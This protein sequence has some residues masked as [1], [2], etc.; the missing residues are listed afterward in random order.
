MER[1]I[2][3]FMAIAKGEDM[4]MAS[5]MIML[6]MVAWFAA[7]LVQQDKRHNAVPR[8][9]SLLCGAWWWVYLAMA[10]YKSIVRYRKNTTAWLTKQV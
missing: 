4:I 9:Y 8:W 2:D 3:R 6:Y 1:I 7:S 5:I 10:L